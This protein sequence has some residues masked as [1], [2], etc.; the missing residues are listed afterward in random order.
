MPVPVP[1]VRAE[2][3]GWEM[4]VPGTSPTRHGVVPMVRRRLLGRWGAGVPPAVP[5][6]VVQASRLPSPE[7]GG[8]PAPQGFRRQAGRLHH[9][10]RFAPLAALVC[11][12]LLAPGRL[13][14]Q[15]EES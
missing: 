1:L 9:N 8:T 2:R 5:L 10:G 4:C 14:A 3:P 6:L 15:G 12:A 7:A 11:L 13:A